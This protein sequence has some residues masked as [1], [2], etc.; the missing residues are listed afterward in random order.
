LDAVQELLTRDTA[1]FG[2]PDLEF[3]GLFDV[4]E[5]FWDNETNSFALDDFLEHLGKRD[6]LFKTDYESYPAIK[7]PLSVGI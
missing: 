7:A 3:S 6:I 1:K 4:V 2:T 5:K